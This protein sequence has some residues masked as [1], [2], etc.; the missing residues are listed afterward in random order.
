MNLK[1]MK[2]VLALSVVI[3]F[4]AAGSAQTKRQ[5]HQVRTIEAESAQSMA[6]RK[7]PGGERERNNRS[8]ARRAAVQTKVN[9]ETLK[10]GPG[11]E[12]KAQ[13]SG[14]SFDGDL[15]DMS[16]GVVVKKER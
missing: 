15:R 4:V 7:S 1:C 9:P 13:R 3:T 12:A 10:F 5:K 8:L 6:E 2:W 16:P 11:R 14:K